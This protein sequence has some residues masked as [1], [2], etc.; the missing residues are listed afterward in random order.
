MQG[1]IVEFEGFAVKSSLITAELEVE[2]TF[3]AIQFLHF[4][5]GVVVSVS[6]CA[7]QA[8]EC[9]SYVVLLQSFVGLTTFPLLSSDVYLLVLKAGRNEFLFRQAVWEPWAQTIRICLHGH[10]CWSR[11]CVVDCLERLL[12]LVQH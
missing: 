1:V 3:Q 7:M 8:S 6:P 11:E 9:P 12:C 5:G 10:T 2:Q 4:A